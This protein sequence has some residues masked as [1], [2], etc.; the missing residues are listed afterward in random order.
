MGNTER[1]DSIGE[2]PNWVAKGNTEVMEDRTEG[3]ESA[4]GMIY[5]ILMPK[6]LRRRLGPGRACYQLRRDLSR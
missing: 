3:T 5:E 1:I 4:L 6:A 2:V